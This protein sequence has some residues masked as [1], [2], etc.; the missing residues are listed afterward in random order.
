MS[1]PLTLLLVWMSGGALGMLFFG[2][3]WWTVRRAVGAKQPALWLLGSLVLRTSAVLAGFY[4]VSGPH[5][6]R[7]LACLVGFI[8]ARF[9]VLRMTR[10]SEEASH[11]A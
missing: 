10:A 5:W 6:E 3:L 9:V 11:A 8:M 4:L 2:G 1:D 7:L